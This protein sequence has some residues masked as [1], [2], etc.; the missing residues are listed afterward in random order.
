MD[1]PANWWYS[2][3]TEQVIPAMESAG[4]KIPQEVDLSQQLEL[5]AT[6]MTGMLVVSSLFGYALSVFIG[7]W[8]QAVR[9]R[10]G[11]FGEEFRQIRLGKVV[12]IL[13]GVFAVLGLLG[14]GQIAEVSNNLLLTGVLL[15]MFQGLAVVHSLNQAKPKRIWLVAMYMAM[16]LLF[17]YGILIMGLIGLVDNGIDIRGRFAKP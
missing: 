12:S 2:H 13:V 7:R 4:F 3:F 1:N 15:F 14:S 11:A 6:L 5:M 9:Y 10:P 17:P 8:W 16:F